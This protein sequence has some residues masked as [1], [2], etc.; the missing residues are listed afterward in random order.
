MIKV[1]AVSVVLPVYCCSEV[2]RQFLVETLESVAAQTLRNIELLIVDDA[3]PI[4]PTSVIE[5][6]KNLPPTRLIRNAINLG[7]AESRNI[8]LRAAESELIAF[9][10]HDDV[11]LPEKLER[12]VR[13]LQENPDAAMCYCNVEITGLHSPNNIYIDQ[14]TIPDRPSIAWFLAHGNSVITASS[15]LVKKQAM[16]DIGLFNTSYT[17]CDDYDAWIKILMRWPI[18]HLPEVLARY[19]LHED[20]VNYSVDRLNDNRLLTHLILGYWRSAPARDK[21]ALLPLLT[22]K[23]F[24]RVLYTIEK[25]GRSRSK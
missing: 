16:L 9:L 8:G 25:I 10:D 6:V 22:R 3:S 12:Q 20:N 24:G 17:S 5:S 19:R 13:T 7:H 4:D 1:P 14:N 15:V 21:L 18:I 2:N 23:F 11:W